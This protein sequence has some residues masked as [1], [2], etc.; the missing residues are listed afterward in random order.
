M[1]SD[2]G[3]IDWLTRLLD[4][5]SHAREL[6]AGLE[7]APGAAGWRLDLTTELTT[8]W[9]NAEPPIAPAGG[10]DV[11]SAAVAVTALSDLRSRRYAALV[12]PVGPP[13]AASGPA[14]RMLLTALDKVFSGLELECERLPHLDSVDAAGGGAWAGG[15]AARRRAVRQAAFFVARLSAME[16]CVRLLMGAPVGTPPPLEPIQA[17]VCRVC[18]ALYLPCLL[19]HTQTLL[20]SAVF[21]EGVRGGGRGEGGQTWAGE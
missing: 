2:R 7:G 10:R 21:G 20:R 15:G 12:S 19:R 5:A 6:A 14:G 4:L 11:S 18:R 9:S 8:D 16:S 17:F 13:G 1:R 3:V